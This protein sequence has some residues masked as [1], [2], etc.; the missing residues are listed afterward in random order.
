MNE[1]EKSINSAINEIGSAGQSLGKKSAETFKYSLKYFM[2]F[3]HISK[4]ELKK[5]MM[6]LAFVVG[7]IAAIWWKAPEIAAFL[8]KKSQVNEVLNRKGFQNI[9][10][11]VKTYRFLAV[12]LIP[13]GYLMAVGDKKFEEARQFTDKF[14]LIGMVKQLEKYVVDEFGT[15]RRLTVTPELI[16]C[17]KPNANITVRLFKTNG[18]PLQVWESKR[19]DLEAAFDEPLY[20]LTNSGNNLNVVKMVTVSPEYKKELDEKYMKEIEYDQVFEKIGLVGKGSREINHFGKKESIKNYPQYLDTE[21]KQIN[22]KDV[23]VLKFRSTGTEITNWQAVKFLMENVLNRLVVKIEQEKK[24][25]QIYKLYTLDLKDD[26]EETYSWNDSNINEEEGVLVLGEG[27]LGKVTLDLNKLPHVLIGGVTNF[28]KSVL[29]N[30]LTWQLIKKGALIIPFDFKGG[31]ELDMFSD[32]HEV[33]FERERAIQVLEKVI[34][35]YEARLD[36]FKQKKGK[37][38]KKIAKFNKM[39]PEE[40]LCRIIVIVDEIAEMLSG[41]STKAEVAQIERLDNQISKIARLA[42][43]TGVHLILGTQRPDSN[44]LQGQI[45]NNLSARICG[46]MI[47]IQPSIMILGTPDA[48]RI[49]DIQG[50]FM[51]SLG[52]EVEIFQAYY[53]QEENIKPGNY[54]KGQCLVYDLGKNQEDK[55]RQVKQRPVRKAIYEDDFESIDPTEGEAVDDDWLTNQIGEPEPEEDFEEGE[56]LEDADEDDSGDDSDPD[57]C[58]NSVEGGGRESNRKRIEII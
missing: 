57:H 33:V 50:R 40:E 14:Q 18:Q 20:Q 12:A 23:E 32:F 8:V 7:S 15:K 13:Y 38:I 27:L 11:S 5:R 56:E 1:L 3:R 58:D 37:N 19:A 9:I 26:L 24:D 54:V 35:E 46:R 43:A 17:H 29:S 42:R 39:Y 21:V 31:I 34:L 16:G 49:P 51:F 41:A 22:G 48:T 45:K 10:A 30:C 47:D 2:E 52:A 53:F 55:E 4:K 25:K 28:G 6:I 44:V 36:L